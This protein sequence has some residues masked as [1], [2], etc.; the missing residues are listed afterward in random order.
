VTVPAKLVITDSLWK[1]TIAVLQQYTARKVEAGCFWYGLRGAE[2]ASALVLGI[3]RQIN[4]PPNFEIPADELAKLTDAACAHAGLVAVAQLHL[5]PGSDVRHSPWDDQQVVSRN[6][7]SLVI[8]HYAKSPI[9]FDRIGIY[10]FEQDR[11][12]RLTPQQARGA[13]V[14]AA[15]VV[16][17]R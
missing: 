2:N 17:T 3:P 8:P 7:Y 6:I 4:R 10:R 9:H 5:H 13:I 12:I 14:I 15:S 11:W 16:D 1:E